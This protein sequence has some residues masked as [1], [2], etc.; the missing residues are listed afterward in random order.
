MFEGNFPF[1]KI[2]ENYQTFVF[3]SPSFFFFRGKHTGAPSY[4]ECQ[5]RRKKKFFNFGGF[6][7]G[8]KG[9][10]GDCLLIKMPKDHQIST[11]KLKEYFDS[12]DPE[13]LFVLEEEIA[14]GSFGAVYK[15][16][17]T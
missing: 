7:T 10:I 12:G 3:P 13:Q 1:G 6:A 17:G 14:S 2:R 11:M 15:V 9:K 5:P 4:I 16:T 8:K